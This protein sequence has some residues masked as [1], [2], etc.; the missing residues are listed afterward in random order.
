[1]TRILHY[2]SSTSVDF[3]HKKVRINS[4]FWQNSMSYAEILKQPL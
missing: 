2:E 1:M 3:K 4:V